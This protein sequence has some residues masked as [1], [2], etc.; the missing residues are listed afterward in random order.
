MHQTQSPPFKTEIKTSAVAF[1]VAWAV[2]SR[3]QAALWFDDR[4][5]WEHTLALYPEELPIVHVNLGNV[6]FREGN[7]EAADKRYRTALELDP[8]S[9]VARTNL[10]WTSLRLKRFDAALAFADDAIR[11][12][13]DSLQGWLAKAVASQLSGR[14]NE[15]VTAY[16]RVL[17]LNPGNPDAVRNLDLLGAEKSAN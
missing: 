8:D 12:D 5:L 14:N 15:A 1:I 13:Q 7:M 11:L 9:I 4:S 2:M 16:R 6:E 3:A 17:E 10:A